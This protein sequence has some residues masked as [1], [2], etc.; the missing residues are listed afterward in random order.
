MTK[1]LMPCDYSCLLYTDQKWLLFFHPLPSQKKILCHACLVLDYLE[2]LFAF[3]KMKHTIFPIFALMFII[4]FLFMPIPSLYVP[5]THTRTKAHKP[6]VEIHAMCDCCTY[7]R[8]CFC[9]FSLAFGYCIFVQTHINRFGFCFG[10][11]LDDGI[12]FSLDVFYT[13]SLSSL[14]A[15]AITGFR[16][17]ISDIFSIEWNEVHDL[18]LSGMLFI[19]F[20]QNFFFAASKQKMITTFAFFFFCF[21]LV[22]FWSIWLIFR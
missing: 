8:F 6:S 22:F 20:F 21:G 16:V 12:L 17:W 15:I 11:W 7:I 19:F 14:M 3:R 1:Y 5:H 9:Y 10:C 13:L 18:D 4:V 2:C